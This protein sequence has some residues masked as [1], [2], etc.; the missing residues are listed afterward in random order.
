MSKR[1][2]LLNGSVYLLA[3]IALVSGYLVVSDILRRNYEDSLSALLQNNLQNSERAVERWVDTRTSEVL[4]HANDPMLLAA[5][6]ELMPLK[7]DVDALLYADA[8][9]R[10]RTFFGSFLYL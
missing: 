5:V 2:R 8:Q 4:A 6:E 3:I 7:G 9:R 1:R 10:L